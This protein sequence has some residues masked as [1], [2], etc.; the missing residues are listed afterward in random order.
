MLPNSKLTLGRFFPSPGLEQTFN[1]LP[2]PSVFSYDQLQDADEILAVT[3]PLYKST[4]HAEALLYGAM[5][6]YCFI[7][8]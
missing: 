4:I 2:F 3:L 8:H 7:N 6:E 1:I 5:K